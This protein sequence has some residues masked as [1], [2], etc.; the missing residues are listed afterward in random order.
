MDACFACGIHVTPPLYSLEG[1]ILCGS[2]VYYLHK[3][4]KLLLST[5]VGGNPYLTRYLMPDGEVVS[6]ERR[7]DEE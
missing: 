6:V 3:F 1:K 4:G 2:C 7:K 5:G